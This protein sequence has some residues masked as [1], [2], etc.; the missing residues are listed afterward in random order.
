[1]LSELANARVTVGWR[2]R[3]AP[4]W[5]FDLA[6]IDRA[7]D[8]LGVRG[9]IHVGC[10]EYPRGRWGGMYSYERGIHRVRVR[11]AHSAL[12]ASATIWHELTHAR[13]QTR[14]E[15]D[16]GGTRSARGAAYDL[17]PREQEARANE[18]RAIT[19][20]LVTEANA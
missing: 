3:I 11:R 1:M 8:E 4:T 6:A 13:Q 12:E 17:H 5:A 14:G 16:D 9:P 19:H 2:T 18:H 10:A 15:R 20:P 7:A